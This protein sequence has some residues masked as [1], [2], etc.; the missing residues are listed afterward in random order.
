V[1]LP[2]LSPKPSRLVRLLLCASALVSA[3]VTALGQ[4]PNPNSYPFSTF[5]CTELAP[6]D[7]GS[8]IVHFGYVNPNLTTQQVIAG[9]FYNTF[10][11]A[12]DLSRVPSNFYPGNHSDAVQ[13]L[14]K[15]QYSETYYLGN[16]RN[17]AAFLNLFNWQAINNSSA[18][19]NPAINAA[20][21]ATQCQPKFFPASLNFTAPGTYPG[22][23]L[24]QVDS[25]P[26]L[27]TTDPKSS[28]GDLVAVN[29]ASSGTP[30]IVITNLRYV[31]MDTASPV[32]S[33]PSNPHYYNPNS[34][35]GDVT[36]TAGAPATG[37][38]DLNLVVNGQIA[39][40]GIVPVVYGGATSSGSACPANVTASVT[41]TL[42]NPTQLFG[43]QLYTQTVMM[44]NTSGAAIPGPITLALTNLSP[45]ARLFTAGGTATCTGIAGAPYIYVT[46]GIP[47]NGN[48]AV[49]L[50]FTN[51][52][53][54]TAAITYTPVV[55]AGG[56][57]L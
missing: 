55:L 37:G 34:I 25:G 1:R 44:K 36:V 15:L 49:V 53:N 11:P 46:S 12:V 10:T 26:I 8:Y 4:F 6:L 16:Y 9:S 48:A 33:D 17:D 3:S 22:Q 57:Q 42:S 23:Y 31:S 35:Y 56:T 21:T 40:G 7:P 24:G 5:T 41:G 54:P 20:I 39:T 52:Q 18:T 19:Q 32:R 28:A 50:T 2:R 38:L 47:A 29:G 45:N 43:T 30:N 51:T 13:A 27:T 14:L